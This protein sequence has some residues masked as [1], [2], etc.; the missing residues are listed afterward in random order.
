MNIKSLFGPSAKTLVGVDIGTSS[1]KVASLR[2]GRGGGYELEALGIEP[3]AHDSIVDGAIISKLEVADA[4]DRLFKSA[5][6]ESARV[7]T[8]ISGHSVIVKTVNLPA[9]SEQELEESI[10]WEA[11]QYVP[12]DISE[13]NLDY[14]VLR[15]AAQGNRMEVLL[16]AAKRDKIIDH[17]GVLSMAGK[18]P[19]VVDIDAFALL[20]AYAAN[21]QPDPSSVVALL[22]VGSNTVNITIARGREFLFT[23][24]VAIGGSHYTEHLQKQLGISFDEAETYK[25]GG[26]PSEELRQRTDAVL[27]DVSEILT[28]EIQ[29]TFDY[30]RT[31]A[32]SAEPRN[33]YLSGGACKTRGLRD[34]LQRKLDVPVD[35]LNP[36]QGIKIDEAK[37][38]PNLL[39]DLATDFAI[40]VGLALRSEAEKKGKREA[41]ASPAIAVNLLREPVRRK[42]QFAAAPSRPAVFMAV[43]AVALA[44]GLGYW[45]RSLSVDVAEKT[46]QVQQLKVESDRLQ[47]LRAELTRFQERKAE[48]ER[49]LAVVEQLRRNQTGPVNLMNSLLAS[50]PD[51]PRLWL[52]SLTQRGGNVTIEGNAFDVPA[53]ANFI[54]ELSRR[55]PFSN[56]ELD[57]WEQDQ[58]SLKFKLSCEVENR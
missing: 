19:A 2:R 1:V 54:S 30:F 11:E 6:I 7:A 17:T 56:V 55:G 16:V 25:A 57:F 9:Q 21:H 26:A 41:A 50:V 27:E 28:L 38:P 23:R 42:T 51:E 47:K 12:F 40:A 34:Y 24:D 49:R 33:V 43:A 3:L 45:W 4:I 31:H 18:R 5:G 20:N 32:E 46:A 35:Y 44:L 39:T 53:I 29:K 14:Q 52:S 36:F 15:K 37:F 8:S 58:D 48:L 22:D 10:R 13:V